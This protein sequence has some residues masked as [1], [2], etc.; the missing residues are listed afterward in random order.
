MTHRRLKLKDEEILS[1]DLIRYFFNTKISLLKKPNQLLDPKKDKRSK[2]GLGFIKIHHKQN[3]RLS[4]DEEKKLTKQKS[5]ATKKFPSFPLDYRQ[6][7][8]KS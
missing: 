7:I 4:T 2:Q 3:R 6:E 5:A 8:S 1:S